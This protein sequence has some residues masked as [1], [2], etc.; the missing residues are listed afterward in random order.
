MNGR[1]DRPGHEPRAVRAPADREF[2]AYLLEVARYRRRA[3]AD[4]LIS[5]LAAEPDLGDGELLNGIALL[6][7]ADTRRPST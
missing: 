4:D 1:A 6:L 3:S 5:A 7:I 2:D